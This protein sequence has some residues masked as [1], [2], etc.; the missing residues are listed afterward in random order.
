MSATPAPTEFPRKAP[1]FLSVQSGDAGLKID[2]STSIGVPPPPS[3]Q[4]KVPFIPRPSLRYVDAKTNLTLD[5]SGDQVR[6]VATEIG[7]LVSVTIRS[8]VDTGSTLFTLL[9]PKVNLPN[10]DEVSISTYGVRT[11]VALGTGPGPNTGQT[12]KYTVTE[13]EGTARWVPLV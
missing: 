4:S 7:T 13:L 3:Q 2:Y 5:F 1:N 9:V 12:E 6:L 11:D 8:T 10:T